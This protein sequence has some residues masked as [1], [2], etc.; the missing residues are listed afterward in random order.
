MSVKDKISKVIDYWFLYEPLFFE[1]YCTHKLESNIDMKCRFRTGK[2]RIEYNPTLLENL[3][4]EEIESLLKIEVTRILL[5]HPY[6]RVPQ[7]PNHSALTTASDVTISEHCG[8]ENDLKG[9]DN[10]KMTRGLSFEEYYKKLCFICPEIESN[11]YISPETEDGEIW[12]YEAAADASAL[13]DE[14]EEMCDS[15][16]QKIQNAIRTNQWGSFTG[17]FQETIIAS[18][19]IPMDYRRILSQFRS[20]IISHRRILTRMKPNRRYGFTYMGSKFEPKT[21]LLV[22]VDV[23]GSIDR[24]DLENFFS[25]INQFFSY[26]VESIHVITFDVEIK[27]ESELKKAYKKI[28]VFGRGGTDF[29]CAVDYYEKHNE[30]Q[31]MI[32]FTDGYADP[33]TVKK[34]KQILWILTGKSEYNEANGWIKHM[35]FNRATWI[36][37]VR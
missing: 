2:K 14:N 37:S 25:I 3:S 12:E 16:N 30:Y 22:A 32:I 29:Q 9:A 31:G 4:T 7:H 15:I 34:N 5:K 21:H 27:Q 17:R 23:S 6:Q 26:G 13:W 20:N 24:K 33:P 36:P 8:F 1:V 10:Y 18:L 11:E 35:R 19:K 28:N